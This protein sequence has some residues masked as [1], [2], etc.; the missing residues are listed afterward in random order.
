MRLE[1]DEF[2]RSLKGQ[3]TEA[4]RKLGELCERLNLKYQEAAA[5]CN[6]EVKLQ[7]S[8]EGYDTFSPYY[9][10]EVALHVARNETVVDTYRIVI[11]E[12][13]RVWF[14]MLTKRNMP[15]SKMVGDWMDKSYK[16]V[17]LELEERMAAF[18]YNRV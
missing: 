17:E 4:E 1:Q 7:L 12:C 16:Q 18:L 5:A 11:W 14:G 13:Q 8:R 6:L 15:G 10:S 3:I 9:R 2:T